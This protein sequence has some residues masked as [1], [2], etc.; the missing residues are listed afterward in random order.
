MDIGMSTASY[1]D[2]KSNGIVHI[3]ISHVGHTKTVLPSLYPLLSQTIRQQQCNTSSGLPVG[4]A[5]KFASLVT[6]VRV[7]LIKKQRI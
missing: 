3:G 5:G 4:L 1:K 2:L 7:E 6:A